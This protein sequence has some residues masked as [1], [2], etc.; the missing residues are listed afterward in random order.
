ML[1]PRKA[2][3]INSSAVIYFLTT[4][5]NTTKTLWTWFVYFLSIVY[6]QFRAT[7]ALKVKKDIQSPKCELLKWGLSRYYFSGIWYRCSRLEYWRIPI[8]LL[9]QQVQFLFVSEVSLRHKTH[10]PKLSALW[11]QPPIG[12]WRL[13]K[14]TF[15]KSFG[16]QWM[17]WKKHYISFVHWQNRFNPL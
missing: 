15:V 3:C 9:R 16:L 12:V 2:T 11:L 14:E 5:L 17:C 6:V 13:E 4:Q 7:A 1:A 10:N 8:S